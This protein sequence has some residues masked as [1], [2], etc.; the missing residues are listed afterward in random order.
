[1]KPL[2]VA[3]L[4][5]L[6]TSVS[7][8]QTIAIVGGTVHTVGPQGSIENATVIITDG[9]IAAVGSDIKPPDGANVIDA[10]GKVV[11][12]GLFTPDGYLGLVEVGLS[13]GP[14][15]AVQRGEQFT[16]SFDVA[17]AFNPRSTLIAINRIE[18]I[19]RAL[20]VPRAA[21]PDLLGYTSNVISGLAAVV[22]LSGNTNSLD[23]RAAALVVNLG[24]GGV[25]YAGTSRASAQLLL[26]NALDE[27]LDYR[28]HGDAFERGQHRDY[29]LSLTDLEALQGV[30]A[31]DIPLFANVDRA[32]DI[33][34]LI[35]LSDDYNIRAIVSGGAEAWMHA[36]ELAAAKIAVILGPADNLPANFDRINARSESAAI[37]AAAD[38]RVMFA[39]GDGHTHN[40]RNIMQSAGNATVAGLSW[41]DSLRAITLTPAE[42]Y[43]VADRVGSIEVG[44]IAD[45]IIWPADPLELTSYP[46]QVFI[47]GKSLPMT[48]RQT[49]LRDRYRDITSDEPPAYR[50]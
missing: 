50:N 38:V 28:E 17:E 15:D 48:S 26:R 1:M 4:L 13:A 46:D 7:A 49:L 3:T 47:N 25:A 41:D 11:T 39:D 21:E 19:T 45:V 5:G 24:E 31:G 37:L 6:L 22:N 8:A 42:V 35:R 20:I 23:R 10:S 33:A 18:G 34:A 2:I 16:A 27:A 32:S 14:L 9:R 30:I 29:T 43:G 40:A 12:P 44:K 36:E